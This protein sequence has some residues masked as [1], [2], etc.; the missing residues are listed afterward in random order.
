[1]TNRQQPSFT[2]GIEEEYFLVSPWT[3]ALIGESPREMLDECK[4][5]LGNQ[6][7]SEFQGSQ[8]EVATTICMSPSEARAELLRLRNLVS[9]IACRYG[10]APIAA[11]T[12][13]FTPWST[14]RHTD[15][16]R[17]DKIADDLQG[18][19][20]RMVIGGMHVH[21]GIEDDEQR[22]AVMN[23]VRCYLP[24]L[25]ALSTSS[26]F[27]QGEDTGLKSFRTSINDA[28]PRKGIP[29]R[30]A[31]WSEYRKT[32]GKLERSGVIEDATKI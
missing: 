18:L 32:V 22:I 2:F 28:S 8:I 9:A 17:Y 30:F 21:V 24:I 23:E 14:Q 29:E 25:L 4:A 12:H 31:S 1:M 26:P 20:R 27:W 13:P 6:F 7:S 16:K 10:L 3:R 19:G 11:S 5:A 15:K